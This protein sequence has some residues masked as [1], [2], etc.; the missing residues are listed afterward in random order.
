MSKYK[1]SRGA[2]ITKV[3]QDG[4]LVVSSPIYK[5]DSHRF[6]RAVI[7]GITK[8]VTQDLREYFQHEKDE[9]LGRWRWPDNPDYLVYRIIDNQGNDTD[10][11]R[12]AM[13]ATGNSVGAYC[14][15]DGI[16]CSG[17]GDAARAYFESHP[18]IKPWHKA[19][20]GEVWEIRLADRLDFIRVLVVKTS[21]DELL[22]RSASGRIDID[23]EDIME[24]TMI[25]GV[26]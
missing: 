11:V 2:E 25:L 5:D 3:D 6:Q 24:A 16:S 21:R 19:K 8:E 18:E 7:T 20:L 1:T 22:F 10:K 14:R 12:V 23:D 9:E 26:D 17:T 13:E 4:S 15:D